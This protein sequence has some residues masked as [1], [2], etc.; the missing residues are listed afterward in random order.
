MPAVGEWLK[1]TKPSAA[2]YVVSFDSGRPALENA[3]PLE[4]LDRLS[5]QNE[6]FADTVTFLGVS[7]E[8]VNPR[9]VTL[10]KDIPG[11]EASYEQI[12]HMMTSGM[13]FTLLPS[14]FYAGY[15]NS[16]SFIRGDVAVFDLRPAN[17]VLTP[18]GYIIPI[19]SI[20]VRLDAESRAILGH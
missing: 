19:D 17:V 15:E 4:Y 11:V 5:I 13:G 8:R 7:G 16:L 20:P 9:I 2:G 12:I 1:F 18:D 3:T 10:Q 14:R 6:I